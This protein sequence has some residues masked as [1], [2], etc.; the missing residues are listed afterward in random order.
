M[1]FIVVKKRELV[2]LTVLFCFRV[3]LFAFVCFPLG[4]K[5]WRLLTDCGFPG[6]FPL[7]FHKNIIF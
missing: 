3:A 6:Y 4:V 2:L 1:S 7:I 5:R